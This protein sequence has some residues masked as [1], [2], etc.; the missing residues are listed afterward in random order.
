MKIA[1]GMFYHEANSFNPTQV[2]KEDFVYCEGE[3]VL[4]RMYAGEIFEKEG[5][6]MIPLVYAVSLPNGLVSREAFDYYS[7][8][9]IDILER[10][11]DIDGIFLHLHGSME[12]SDIGSGEYE[13][14]KRIR[15][16]V[17]REKIVGIV[18]DIH[19]NTHPEFVKFVNI[20]RHYRTVPHI[21]QR[22]SEHIVARQMLRCLRENIK[23]SPVFFQLPYAIHPEKALGTVW[24]L[25]EI[26]KMLCETE[27]KTGIAIA[28]LGIGM[29]WCDCPTLH[30][31][32][33]VTPQSADFTGTAEKEARNLA[34][35]VYSLRD[36]FDFDQLP[37]LPH[38]AMR[39]SLAY[40]GGPV[41]VSDSGDNTT[42]GAV[43]DHTTLL[44][45]YL[46]ARN[47][48][49]KKVIIT[50]IWDEKTVAECI[51]HREGER[52]TVSIGHGKNEDSKAVTVTAV[53]KKKGE[54][55]GYMSCETDTVGNSVTLTAG[56]I[57]IVITD[58]PGSFISAHHFN[59]AGLNLEEY[60]VIVVKQGYLFAELREK[61]D[62]AILALTNGATNMMIEKLPFKRITPPVYPL[63]YVK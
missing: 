35:Y 41:Y 55:K 38:E 42:G 29:V 32:I 20:I 54:L 62:L 11:K 37:L 19:A 7:G 31:N 52:L 33:I 49:G 45:E 63:T 13:L 58:K 60:H 46:S 8:R 18:F 30:T 40:K 10:N 6:E 50:S 15:D 28:S 17:G 43:G 48:N 21:D 26:F 39:Y 2:R 1:V 59:A 25:S 53:L 51:K 27:K 5:V 34:D 47:L 9:I 12:V 3:D 44:R 24:P 61:A 57:D 23:T 14:L 16:V 36:S 4:K 56:N 22:E